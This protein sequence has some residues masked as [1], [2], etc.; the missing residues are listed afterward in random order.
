MP[1]R[2]LVA[3]VHSHEVA[4][5]WHRSMMHLARWDAAEANQIAGYL[6]MRC[7]FEGVPAARNGAVRAFLA[8]EPAIDWLWWID[9]DMGFQPETIARLLDVAD[10][11]ERP[12]VGALCFGQKL[13]A[14]DGLNG[15]RAEVVPTIYDWHSSEE[16]R[17]FICRTC[18]PRDELV[19][20][21]GTGSACL[22]IHRRVFECIAQTQREPWYQPV[23]NPEVGG[24]IGEDL[25]FCLRCAIAGIPI[26]VH[27]GIKTNHQKLTWLSEDNPPDD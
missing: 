4:Y 27:T 16:T 21:A 19:R 2:V 9:T 7:G 20:C 18:W 22:L 23:P 17:G 1:G 6:E 25:S 10:P 24:E 12:A 13:V 8:I 26:H 11:V 3:Y 14:T 5:S 15:Y